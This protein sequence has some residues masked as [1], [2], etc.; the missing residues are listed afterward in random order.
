MINGKYVHI[1]PM[2][3][4]PVPHKRE[5]LGNFFYCTLQV[6]LH[7]ETDSVH[8][9]EAYKVPVIT[10]NLQDE[11]VCFLVT[12]NLQSQ[13]VALNCTVQDQSQRSI[14]SEAC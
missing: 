7:K 3:P 6:G 9:V 4:H 2:W 5:G 13:F 12:T 1:S 10:G 14:L 8:L 11:H